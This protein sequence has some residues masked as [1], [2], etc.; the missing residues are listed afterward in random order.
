[1]ALLT[2]KRTASLSQSDNNIGQVKGQRKRPPAVIHM[3]LDGATDIF[4][5][6][7][8]SFSDPVDPIFETGLRNSLDFFERNQIRATLFVIA[9]SLDNPRKRV[10]LEEAVQR[11]HEIASHTLTHPDMFAVT[12]AEKRREIFESRAKLESLLD[13]TVR[14]FRAP[15]YRIDRESCELLAEA[16]YEYDALAFPSSVF[17]KRLQCPVDRLKTAHYPLPGRTLM[18]LPLPDHRPSP[19]P[20]NP[21]YALV[22]GDWYFRWGLRK[23]RLMETP[24]V[25]LF[26]LIDWAEPLPAAY[27]K[28]WRSRVFTLSTLTAEKKRSRCQ[29]MIEFVRLN[30]RLTTTSTL[31]REYRRVQR[32]GT[33]GDPGNRTFACLAGEQQS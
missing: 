22:I 4:K 2:R 27:L 33:E 23:A 9:N 30:Y 26:H 13:V 6:H 1:M 31:L 15:G 17:A 18:E 21:S 20:Y 8:W 32:H 14:G 29:K 7:G 25:L 11:G 10:L 16:G 28:S 24:L 12:R 5:M 19:L 3:D